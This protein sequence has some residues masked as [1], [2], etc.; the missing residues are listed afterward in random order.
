MVTVLVLDEP[1]SVIPT[2]TWEGEQPVLCSIPV[3]D[4]L[5]GDDGGGGNDGGVGDEVN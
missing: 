2:E 3:S 4:H 1:P 5:H